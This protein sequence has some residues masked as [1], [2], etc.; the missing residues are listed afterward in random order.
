M[1]KK[2]VVLKPQYMN[3]FQCIGPSCPDTCCAGWKID[4]DKRTYKNYRNIRNKDIA[5]KVSEFVVRNKEESNDEKYAYIQAKEGAC[6]FLNNG[7]CDIQLNFGEDYLSKTCL[8][9]PRVFNFVDERVE[10]SAKLSCPEIARLAL[11]NE[12][13][14]EFDLDEEVLDARH[15]YSRALS[16]TSIW[17]NCF[18]EIRTFVIDL[19]QNRDFTV[20]ERMI[21]LGMFCEKLNSVVDSDDKSIILK[22][23]SDFKVRMHMSATKQQ[24]NELPMVIHVQIKL[25]M[26]MIYFRQSNHAKFNEYSKQ[27]NVAFSIETMD[28]KVVEECFVRGFEKYYK[29]FIEEH[30]YV[31]ENF[32][33][34]QVFERLFLIG[35]HVNVLDDYILLVILYSIV[36]FYIQGVATYNKQM[37]L[38]EAIS[39]I[40]TCA[41]VIEHSPAFLKN[42]SEHIKNSEFDTWAL[43]MVLVKE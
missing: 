34:N 13:P 22:V 23:I 31:L 24:L 15:H 29:P 37:S 39:I 16:T 11:S 27:S 2:F 20:S 30:S 4:I 41:K 25:L 9:Y 8:T 3:Q 35:N 17:H 38:D 5:N 6:G 40:Q 43:L 32:L 21:L 26:E 19:L 12:K 42:L 36:R 14:M 7:L 28:A 10:L 33:V 18:W 1:K